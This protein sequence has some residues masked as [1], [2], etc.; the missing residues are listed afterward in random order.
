MT[1]TRIV[2]LGIA[3]VPANEHL[4]RVRRLVSACE[5]QGMNFSFALHRD[6]SL[7]PHLSI[8]QGVFADSNEAIAVADAIDRSELVVSLVV[9]NLSIWARKIL[10]LNFVETNWLKRFHKNAFHSWM[11]LSKRTSA[12]PQKFTGITAGQQAAYDDTGYPFALAEYAPHITLA[13]F[14]EEQSEASKDFPR[15]L[16]ESEL[17]EVQFERLVVFKVEPLGACREILREWRF[18]K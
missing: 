14:A 15:L 13:H 5:N 9:S 12:D 11:P 4:E 10:F 1:E 2:P 3:L 17:N 7:I 16:A 6:S 18:R 8:M